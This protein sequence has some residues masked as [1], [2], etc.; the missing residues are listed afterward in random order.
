MEGIFAKLPYYIHPYSG[1]SAI[2]PPQAQGAEYMYIPPGQMESIKEDPC[3]VSNP[4][5]DFF[6]RFDFFRSNMHAFRLWCLSYKV[7]DEQKEAFILSPEKDEY[8]YEE[9]VR[10][11]CR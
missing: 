9:Y 2:V 11:A 8:D 3:V 1:A 5:F 10:F 4:E 7:S 6:C